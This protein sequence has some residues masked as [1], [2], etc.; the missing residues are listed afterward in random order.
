MLHSYKAVTSRWILKKKKKLVKKKYLN[1]FY[2][3]RYCDKS[4]SV[5]NKV[6]K[7]Y[8]KDVFLNTVLHKKINYKTHGA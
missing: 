3:I 8:Y 7:T 6:L 1:E 5:N 4:K 2:F